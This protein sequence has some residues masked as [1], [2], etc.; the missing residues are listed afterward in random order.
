[1]RGSRF[2]IQRRIQNWSWRP[3]YSRRTRA[4]RERDVHGQRPCLSHHVWRPCDTRPEQPSGPVCHTRPTRAAD[5][6]P[7]DWWLLSFSLFLLNI[8]FPSHFIP[9]RKIRISQVL[10]FSLNFS[11]LSNT[12]TFSYEVGIGWFKLEIVCIPVLYLFQL[13]L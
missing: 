6:A 13:V 5:M 4:M 10:K 2:V 1:M 8:S 3:E 7:R 11:H 9:W 12:I